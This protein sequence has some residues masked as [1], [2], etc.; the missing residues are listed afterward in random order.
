MKICPKLHK[1]FNHPK[2][3]RKLVQIRWHKGAGTKMHKC[4]YKL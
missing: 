2:H 3:C 4:Y 1:K